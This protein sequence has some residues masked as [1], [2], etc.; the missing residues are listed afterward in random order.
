V[1]CRGFPQA[2]G[3]PSVRNVLSYLVLDISTPTHYPETA[4]MAVGRP[5]FD[6]ILTDRT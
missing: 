3:V 2:T 4:N 1:K 6:A 5:H